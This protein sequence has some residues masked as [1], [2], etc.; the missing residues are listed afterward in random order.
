ML[1]AKKIGTELE[2]MSRKGIVDGIQADLIAIAE[3]KEKRTEREQ[4]I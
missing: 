4:E 3:G 2:V 1:S